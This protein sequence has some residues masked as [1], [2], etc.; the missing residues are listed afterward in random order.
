MFAISKMEGFVMNYQDLNQ[1]DVQNKSVF[2]RIDGN[3]PIAKKKVLD[4]SR[5]MAHCATINHLMGKGAKTIIGTHIGRPELPEA[6]PKNNINSN[7]LDTDAQII[8]KYLQ[9]IYGDKI[10]FADSCVGEDVEQTI[11]NLHNGHLLL[12]QNLRYEKG[13]Q[14]IE[15]SEKRDFAMTLATYFDIYVNDALSVC[16]NNDASIAYLPR[17][18]KKTA[19][20]LLLKKELH[21]MEKLLNPVPPAAA[22]LGGFKVQDK[23]GALQKLLKK[24]FDVFIGGAMRNPFLRFHKYPIGNSVLP[25]HYDDLI[26][27]MIEDFR[28]KIHI[29]FDVRV[30]RFEGKGKKKIGNLRHVDFLQNEE[31]Y[32]G[33]EALDN[34]PK[35][36]SSYGKIVRQRGF[37]TMFANGPFG[38][39]EHR[40]FRSGT[41]QL[42]RIFLENQQALR[43]YGGGD[44][45]HGFNLFSRYFHKDAAELG[46]RC[47]AGN[48]V[49]QFI[50]N[51]GD[52]PGLRALY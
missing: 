17:F 15:E 13:E 41:F 34:G 32:A 49:L 29:P 1:L 16:Q 40:S 39:I 22:F 37:R 27:Q 28:D 46:E 11:R 4:G 44:I 3:V 38:F 12:L 8:F 24:G 14:S 21:L 52:L 5:I 18:T 9:K 25:S 31:V 50:A 10:S 43:V 6:N 45:I 20:G 2:L 42:A 26:H 33:E 30:G 7:R 47:Y 51:D 35:T 23:I 19:I 36:M 48:G